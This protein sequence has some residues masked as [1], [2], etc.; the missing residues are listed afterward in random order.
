[1]ALC[2]EL[3][4]NALEAVGQFSEACRGY[5]LMTS[6]EYATTPTLA[7]LF[8]TPTVESA[9]QFF[10]YGFF[11]PLFL[12]LVAWGYGTIINFVND[13]TGKLNDTIED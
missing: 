8:A 2:V 3:V 1:M 13:R 6:D 7:A 11:T 10:Q 12:W 5:A 4:G 9:R